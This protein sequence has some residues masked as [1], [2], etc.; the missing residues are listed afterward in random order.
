MSIFM[1]VEVTH[2]V[3]V[4]GASLRCEHAQNASAAT[5][6]QHNFVTKIGICCVLIYIIVC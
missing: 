5:N 1:R 3:N 6:V 4:F 2:S